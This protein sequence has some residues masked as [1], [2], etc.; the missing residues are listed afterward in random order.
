MPAHRLN[1]RNALPPGR[2]TSRPRG[3]IRRM[4]RVKP[5]P[6]AEHDSDRAVRDQLQRILASTTF[7]QVDRL[8]RFL[9]FI[10]GEA[11]EGRRHELKEYVIG[12]QVFGKE[13]TFDPRTDPIVRVQARR[14]RSKLVRYYREEGR[15]DEWI[16]ELPK[17]G[18]AP[19]FKRRDTAV[20]VKRTISAALVSRNTI[21]VF[22]FADHS[23]TH[24]LDYFCKG[25]RDEIVH[26]IARFP[27]LRILA[28]DSA[29]T[30]GALMINGSVRRSGNRVRV[31]AQMIDGGSGSYLWS[32]SVDASIEDALGTHEQVARAIV[33]KLEGEIDGRGAASS[34]RPTENL[35]A[36]NLYL[37]GRYHLS[38]RTEEG[39]RKALDFFEKALAEDAEASL[40]HSGLA[41]AYGLLAHYGVLGPADVWTKA[42][43]SAAAAVM[44]DER[45]AE[46]HTSLAHVKSTQD[47]DWVGSER[48]FQRAIACNPRYATA[49]HWYAM[50]CLAPLGRLDEARDEMLLA[51]SLDPVSSIVA[52]D[53]AVIHFY[54]R[55]FETALE[56]CDHTIELNPHFAPGY[57]IL[58]VIQEQRQDFDE[59]LA[60][61]QRAVH[62]SPQTPRMHGALGRTF[63]LSGKR[64]QA[65]EVL[66]K[67]EAYATER[68]VSPLEFAWIQFALGD[69]D[70]GFK[71]LT[72][73]CE[74]RSFDLISIKVDPRFDPLAD[75]PRFAALA[76]HLHPEST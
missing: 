51:Q 10:V 71:W 30:T 9:T 29:D 55:D 68:Y 76:K 1:T 56:Q 44:L 5:A 34:R 69:V 47:W 70:L 17:G 36:H 63:A 50:S 12:V 25:L 42:A 21:A 32:E 66:K 62:L 28:S 38:Q 43:S 49:H 8:K 18:Y 39:L 40:A 6:P 74:D 64:K 2:L 26:H 7:Q 45:S 24:D 46:A 72:K 35:A 33:S 58:G 14:L 75:D 61:F 48:E 52:R 20:L 11:I 16:I 53:L 13:D 37:Q 27:G 57:W 59:S 73:A 23:A 4:T 22:P 15:S 19:T 65:L 3:N 41:D 67:L 31:T 60:A 54:R